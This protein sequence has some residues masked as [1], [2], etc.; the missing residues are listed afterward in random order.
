MKLL[1]LP[2]TSCIANRAREGGFSLAELVV[3]AGLAAAVFSTA[4][5]AFRTI[6]MHQKRSTAYQ[7]IALGPAITKAFFDNPTG[8]LDV[9]TAPNYGMTA[10][11]DIMRGIFWDDIAHASAVY[12]LPRPRITV[13][14]A[15]S[16]NDKVRGVNYLHP[17]NIDV[18]AA[19]GQA[20]FV[21]TSLDHPNA[22]RALLAA[23]APVDS[24][25]N[26]FPFLNDY[27]G[28]P[29]TTDVNGSIFILQMSN[30]DYTLSVRAIYDLDL[31]D[32]ADPLGS[33][34]ACVKRF[35]GDTLT[36]YYDVLYPGPGNDQGPTMFGP[37]FACF[38][39]SVRK[40]FTEPTGVATQA[41]AFKR[42]SDRP[43]YFAWWPDPA[44]PRLA[45]V[46]T[47]TTYAASDARSYYAKHEQQTSWMFT[48]PMFPPL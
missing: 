37:A 27:R 14:T 11:A 29:A 32:V 8:K 22:F 12:C 33:T 39:R 18:T 2:D 24:A 42:A 47:G 35:D 20:P 30:N 3:V 21:G 46:A 44:C 4:A 9:Y 31:L 7:E 36:N 43:F 16:T 28:V 15:T 13:D 17:K 38:E 10:R 1:P 26:P 45:G 6:T 5:L 19:S 40:A 25:T 34:Y 48:F 23:K 41:N